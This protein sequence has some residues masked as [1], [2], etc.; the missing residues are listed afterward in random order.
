MKIKY[1]ELAI[2]IK[3]SLF[4][5]IN[6]VSMIVTGVLAAILGGI[7]GVLLTTNLIYLLIINL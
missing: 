6:L 7:G 2:P 5:K 1:V 3:L 4:H